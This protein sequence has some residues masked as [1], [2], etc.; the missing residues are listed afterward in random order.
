MPKLRVAISPGLTEVWISRRVARHLGVGRTQRIELCFGRCEMDVQVRVLRRTQR[1]LM[2]I[3]PTVSRNLHLPQQ[4]RLHW[5]STRQR[6]RRRLEMG[7][8]VGVLGRN[9]TAP[10]RRMLEGARAEGVYAYLFTPERVDWSRN[11]VHGIVPARRGWRRVTAPLPDVVFDRAMGPTPNGAFWQ[12]LQEREIAVF[13]EDFGDK[14][15]V[16]RR[17][18][19]VEGIRRHLPETYHISR[20]EQAVERI[21]QWGAAYMKSSTEHMGAAI[22]RIRRAASGR[23]QVRT[24]HAGDSLVDESG[25]LYRCRELLQQGIDLLQREINLARVDGGIVDIRSLVVRN[26]AGEWQ[27]G[28]LNARVGRPGT[29][30]SNL[31][32]GGRLMHVRSLLHRIYSKRPAKV[33][34]KIQS[35]LRLSRRVARA[36]AGTD[37]RVADMGV[38]IGIDRKG[39]LWIIEV[40]PK[41]GRGVRG[42]RSIY[43]SPFAYARSLAGFSRKA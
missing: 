20:A 25:L 37:A 31:H 13:N 6:G 11:I 42:H 2:W 36:M 21:R 35:M 1:S 8:V 32:G 14:W 17:L 5:R 39:R 34:R 41:P 24:T 22:V 33:Q 3:P 27:V 26:G 4:I 12:L 7:P 23:Y 29:I 28:A 19:R 40:N 10:Y 38:D 30:V 15:D 18:E 9:L 43:E 16:H